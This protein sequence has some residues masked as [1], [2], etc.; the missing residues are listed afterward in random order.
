MGLV[1][2]DRKRVTITAELAAKP[3]L[4]FCEPITGLDGNQLTV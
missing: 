2:T 1:L 3:E 4:F